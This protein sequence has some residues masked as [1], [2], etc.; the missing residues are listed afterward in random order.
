VLPIDT[1]RAAALVSPVQMDED[2][3]MS[4]DEADE[5]RGG[6]GGGSDHSQRAFRRG[7][8]LQQPENFLS[9]LKRDSPFDAF[10]DAESSYERLPFTRSPLAG[11]AGRSTS[12]QSR[13]GGVGTSNGNLT[14]GG[15][16]TVGLYM[17][18]TRF[19]IP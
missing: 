15:N 19:H 2:S 4:A 3:F 12:S 7:H 17:K 8:L 6:G 18:G 9:P 16:T 14:D 1:K 5:E 11:R 10:V 13:G